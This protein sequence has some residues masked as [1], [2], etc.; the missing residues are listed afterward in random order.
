MENS[1]CNSQKPRQHPQSQI[2]Q[3]RQAVQKKNAK[4]MGKEQ[5]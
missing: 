2:N 1:G 5:Q 3:M 4:L